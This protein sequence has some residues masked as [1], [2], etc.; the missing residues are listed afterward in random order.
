MILTHE[1][2]DLNPDNNYYRLINGTSTES[3]LISFKG[4]S[5]IGIQVYAPQKN[6]TNTRIEVINDEKGIIKLGGV[7]SYGLKLS[8][9]ILD[10]STN[11]NKSVFENK[12]L[13]EISGSGGNSL[14]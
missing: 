12:G 13:I 10:K 4:K 7:E 8:S 1:F 11:G 2:D 6:S 14:S 5:S 9:R 3:G